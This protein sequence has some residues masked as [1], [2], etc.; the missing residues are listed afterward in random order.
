MIAKRVQEEQELSKQQLKRK[1][2]VQK[3]AQFY[4]EEDWDTIRA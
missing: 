1:A 4:N 3:A 2:E